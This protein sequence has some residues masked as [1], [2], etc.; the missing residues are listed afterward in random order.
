MKN[1][2]PQARYYFKLAKIWIFADKITWLG[3]LAWVVVLNL[4][5]FHGLLFHFYFAPFEH[6]MKYYSVDPIKP[7]FE[8]DQ[9]LKFISH[10]D[11]NSSVVITFNDVL[12]CQ[13]EVGDYERY[14][15]QRTERS[16]TKVGVDRYTVWPY[17]PGVA[18]PTTCCL[19]SNITLHL[20]LHV[21][22]TSVYDGC[23]EGK[24]F[25]IVEKKK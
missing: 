9:R 12:F 2:K 19:E 11:L 23:F 8:V 17:S 22:R 1:F 21:D 15:S 10:T 7:E 4:L 6:W 5:I 14:S 13:D 16:H 3:R 24:T 25:K 18:Y 20:P